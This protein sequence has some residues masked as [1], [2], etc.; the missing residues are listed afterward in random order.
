MRARNYTQLA[1]A[2]SRTRSLW[3]PGQHPS[4]RARARWAL[5]FATVAVLG[6]PALAV[7]PSATSPAAAGITGDKTK[8]AQLEQKIAA[9]GAAVQTLVTREDR[10]T[11]QLA[12]IRSEIAL[13]QS[14]LTNDR[15]KESTAAAR[16]R[17][18]AIEA[19]INDASGNSS[20]LASI[21]NSK[22]VAALPEQ[23]AY[24]GFASGTLDA[25]VTTLEQDQYLISTTETRLNSEEAATTVTLQQLGTAQSAAQ[26]AVNSDQTTLRQVNGN[27]LALVTAAEQRREAAQQKAE[28]A[29][30]AAAA[31][32]AQTSAP[33]TAPAAQPTPGS[34][35]NPL[36]GIGGLSPERIDQ[37]VDYGGYGPIFALGDGVVLS[38]VNWGWPGGTFIAYRLTDG[39]A[40]GLVVYAAEDI[41]PRVQIGESVTS[42]TVLGEVYEGSDGIETGWSDAAANGSTM[43]A[44]YGQY[45]GGNSTAFGYNFSR[46]LSSL[47]AP[48]GQLQ[49]AVSGGLPVGWP[50]F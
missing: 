4:V 7:V 23:E 42:N 44:N 6:G 18:A 43:A 36:R 5:I 47:G 39:P 31:A 2:R 27:L 22:N 1:A 9:Q 33:A 48:G 20:G 26:S 46:L 34:Y 35:A 32:Q 17:T 49:G 50:S 3:R 25:A 29:A 15:R 30:L 10:V 12:T 13:D 37:G 19:Y 14:H 41:E 28:E 16:L 38:T 8:I 24:L 40:A 11:S 45:Y 21:V